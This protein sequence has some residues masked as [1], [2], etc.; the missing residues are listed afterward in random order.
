MKKENP[1]ILKPILLIIISFLCLQTS[2][3]Q[4]KGYFS[5]N[6]VVDLSESSSKIY[7]ATNNAILVHDVHTGGVETFNTVDGLSS[8]NISTIYYRQQNNSL[9]IGYQNGLL[10]IYNFNNK[11]II[12]KFDIVNQTGISINKRKI[13]TIHEY[14]GMLYLGTDYGISLYNPETNLFGNTFFIGFNASETEVL[15]ITIFDDYIY[16]VTQFNGIK[17]ALVNN[18]FL[19]DFNNW[20]TFSNSAFKKI[21]QHQGQLLL[22]SNSGIHAIDNNTINLIH[23]GFNPIDIHSNNQTVVATSN[24][25]V[26]FLN[27]NLVFSQEINLNQLTNIQPGFTKVSL[28]QNY[29]FVGTRENGLLKSGVPF[30]LTPEIILPTGPLNNNAYRMHV[31]PSGNSVW[32]SYGEAS[33]FF[34]PYP[35]RQRPVSNMNNG[36]WTHI[37]FSD[38]LGARSLVNLISDPNDENTM[39]FSSGFDGILKMQNNTGVQ[40]INNTNSNLPVKPTDPGLGNRIF[41]MSFDNK[42]ELWVTNSLIDKQ[43]LSVNR[44]N[45]WVNF[46]ASGALSNFGQHYPDL[47]VD[48]NNTKWIATQGTGVLGFNENANPRFKVVNSMSGDAEESKQVMTIAVDK[49]GQ[50]WIGTRSGLRILRSVDRFMTDPILN[51][52]NIVIEEDGLGQELLNRQFITKIL[53]DG[54]NNKW[55]GT[56]DQGVFLFSANG[57]ETLLR[58]TKENSPLPSNSIK[59]IA[60]NEVTGEVFFL[61]NQGIVSYQGSATAA[62][63]DL[64]N[65]VIYPNPVRPEYQG[66]VK[67]TGLID[68]ANIKITDISGNL[69]HETTST[70][71]TIEWDTTAFGKYKVASGVYMVFIASDDLDETK[72]KKIMIV[73]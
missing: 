23:G 63:D 5:Y 66:T 51:S 37:P 10:S 39:Y 7:V 15:S 73:R 53:V 61:T 9:Y 70:G 35:L 64:S 16:A 46:D 19:I 26:V 71:G 14:N 68:N 54:A 27:Q 55:V 22:I 4:W 57:Q 72:V 6:H 30:S 38:L 40:L 36:V 59:D 1:N 24:N 2:N 17:R 42:K 69:V 31:T 32:L 47:V 29:A 52:T 41:G 50:L 34:N 25:K 62:R 65:V 33:V 13:N 12:N 18:P 43:I 20:Q 58:F 44:N 67:I 3:A 11:R 8:E 56:G 60:I 49:R 45:Q 28:V 48:K 21:I